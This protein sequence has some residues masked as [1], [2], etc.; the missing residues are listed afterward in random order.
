MKLDKAYKILE[1]NKQTYNEIAEEFNQTRNK[2]DYLINE[3][4]KYIK[5]N[6]KVLDLGCGS[7]RLCSLFFT[8]SELI[9]DRVNINYTGIDFAENLV[10]IAERKYG[11]YFKTG[12]ILNL[13]FSDE[14]FDSVW[15]IAVLHHIPSFELRKRV[16]NEIKRVLKP[17][18]RVIITCWKIKSLLRKDIF[19]PFQGKKRYYHIF[20][21][22]EIKKMFEKAG[23]KIEELKTLRDGKKKNILVV[24]RRLE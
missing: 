14:N 21:K 12:D 8:R 7:G 23:F 15:S 18:G 16:L 1:E 9:S 17:N 24:A 4:K 13:P 20:S 2:Y 5:I 11:D 6:E 22:K 19:I 10:K 3:L